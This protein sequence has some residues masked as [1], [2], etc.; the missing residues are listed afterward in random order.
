M[1]GGILVQKTVKDILPQLQTNYQGVRMLN[2]HTLVPSDL[3][4]VIHRSKASLNSSA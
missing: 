2:A 3:V 4:N 1:I